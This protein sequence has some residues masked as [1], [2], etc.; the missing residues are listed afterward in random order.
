LP[1]VFNKKAGPNH[2]SWPTRRQLQHGGQM[3]YV[4]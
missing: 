2:A 3:T 4:R 1:S